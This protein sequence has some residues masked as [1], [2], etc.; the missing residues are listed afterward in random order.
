MSNKIV[1]ALLG[2]FVTL[3]ALMSSVQAKTYVEPFW[4]GIQFTTRAMPA[5]VN[6]KSGQVQALPMNVLNSKTMGSGK[7]FQT[8]NLQATLSP[9]MSTAPYGAM[10]RSNLPDQGN[11]GV[12]CDP[13]TFSNM[14]KETYKPQQ[15]EG[16]CSSGGC[17]TGVPACGKMNVGAMGHAI[18]NDS[19]YPAPGYTNGNYQNVYDSLGDNAMSVGANIPVGTMETVDA[20]GENEQFVTFNRLMYANRPSNRTYGQGCFFRGDLAITPDNTG[21]FSVSPNIATDLNPGAM[22]VLAGAG[23]GGASNNDLMTLLVQSTGGTRST[24]GGVDLAEMVPQ[25]VNMNAQ[26]TT[27]L[28]ANLGDINTQLYP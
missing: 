15:K 28:L 16:F 11:L 13:L 9:R 24:F 17:D 26:A 19:D 27:Q 7:F 2:I 12:P 3:L 20:E 25:N 8:A 21:W 10:I 22:G 1:I 5:V 18:T 23:G 4:G 6:S 14:A